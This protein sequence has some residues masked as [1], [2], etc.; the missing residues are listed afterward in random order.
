VSEGAPQRPRAAARALAAALA[1]AAALA[2]ATLVAGCARKLP[3]SGGP[4]DLLPP[5]LLATDPDSG[6]VKVKAGTAIKLEFSKTMD[7]ASVGANIVLAPGVRN[8]KLQW[9]DSHTLDLIPDPP[10]VAGRTY[11]LL[12]P[13]GARDIRGNS[14]GHGRTVHFATADSFPPGEI[15]GRVEGRG[16]PGEGVY[17][18]AYRE[19]LHHAPDSTAF[20]MDALAQAGAGGE[21]RMPGL[22]V[23]ATYRLFTFADRNRNRSF[24]PGSDLLTRS[25]SLVSL[26]P[27]APR[28]VGVRVFA[29]D[30]LA[31]VIATGT[32]IDSLAPGTAP[33]LVEV[34][35]VPVDT[36]I[37]ADRVPVSVVP[38]VERKFQANLRAGRWTFVAFRDL[39][40]DGARSP[41]EPA[42]PPVRVDVSPGVVPP[43]IRLV[44]PETAP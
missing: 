30:P 36:T 8:L 24:E 14:L 16:L 43:L 19:D 37:A 23:P 34:R 9:K 26:A 6:A 28:A 20:D 27:G 1:C 41:G 22:A 25:D 5:T 7:R 11:A 18:W 3:P 29:T 38:V 13:P 44:L 35:V 10:L 21:F 32:V 40:G 2:L 31:N 17:V 39:N 33:L 4:L 42:S 15:A 12:V